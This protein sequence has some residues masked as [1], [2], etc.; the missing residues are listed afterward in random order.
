[1]NKLRERPLALWP[2]GEGGAS[3]LVGLFILAIA[4]FL[5]ASPLFSRSASAQEAALRVVDG[6]IVNGTA[7]GGSV[8][9]HT[10]VFHEE[11]AAR[12]DHLETKA[13]ADGRF[14][15]ESIK[16]D[17]DV[18]YGVSTVYQDALYGVDLDLTAGSPEPVTLTVYDA[19]T[20][21]SVLSVP[22]VSM[23]VSQA[24]KIDRLIWALEIYKISNSSDRTFIPGQEGPMSLLRFGLPEGA[25]DLQVDTSIAGAQLFTVDRGFAIDANIPPGE[26]EVMFA[27]T[28]PYE[29]DTASLTKTLWYGA[30]DMRVLLPQ[31]IADLASPALGPQSQV[32]IGGR[33]YDLLQAQGFTRG[34]TV[35][36]E[37]TN[38]PV[39]SSRERLVEAF[40]SL[41]MELVVPVAMGIFLAG[42][43]VIVVMRSRRSK[44]TP[45]AVPVEARARSGA[46]EQSVLVERL[47][48]LEESFERGD[49]AEADYARRREEITRQL[50]ALARRQSP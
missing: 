37:F 27:Y 41:R 6:R 19:I 21:D 34:E 16:F 12:H 24:D 33:T 46:V 18:A 42:L 5:L 50:T 44:A 47:A 15:F 11:G 28:F 38:L 32:E 23:L 43:I 13:D 45:S 17:P 10:I 9:G 31:E 14:R 25:Q 30:G 29:G 40:R 49:I 20:Q 39:A 3:P 2:K 35:S 48:R 8:E 1:V 22:S 7:D 36:V 26:Y 4:V